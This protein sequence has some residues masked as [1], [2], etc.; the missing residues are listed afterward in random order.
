MTNIISK[1]TGVSVACLLLACGASATNLT[2][3]NND[4][5]QVN[6]VVEPGNGTVTPSSPAVKQIVKPGEEISLTINKELL[7]NADTFSVRGSV[8]VP[9]SNNKCGPLSFYND[10]KIVFESGKAGTIICTHAIQ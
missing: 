1:L 6:V 3:K 8:N 7:D 10:Y 9:S 2:I 5:V 4:T